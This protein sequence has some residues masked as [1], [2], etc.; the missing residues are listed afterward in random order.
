MN[1]KWFGARMTG[2]AGGT[3][4]ELMTRERKNPHEYREVNDRTAS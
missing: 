3:F 1:E 4:S 2:P